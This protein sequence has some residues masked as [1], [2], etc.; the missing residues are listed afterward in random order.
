M[1]SSAVCILISWAAAEAGRSGRRF[2][3]DLRPERL[4]RKVWKVFARSLIRREVGTALAGPRSH[5]QS[6]GWIQARGVSTHNRG[7][8]VEYEIRRF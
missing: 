4:M 5:M 7:G 2:D 1:L 8:I 3:A 6:A